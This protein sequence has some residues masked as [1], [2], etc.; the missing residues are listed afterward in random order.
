MLVV[1]LY[2]QTILFMPFLFNVMLFSTV[3]LFHLLSLCVYIYFRA[4]AV[5]SHKNVRFTH[6]HIPQMQKNPFDQ[7][8]IG[9]LVY[10]VVCVRVSLYDFEYLLLL[11]FFSFKSVATVSTI[12]SFALYI[13]R[14]TASP[15]Y[16][17]LHMQCVTST[18]YMEMINDRM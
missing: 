2:Y 12:R 4:G 14:H 13:N 17:T 9:S 10:Y 6:N 1:T 15:V 8:N 5:A 3:F 7:H 16:Q 18:I 11:S